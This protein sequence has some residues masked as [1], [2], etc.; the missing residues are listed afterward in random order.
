[1]NNSNCF[2]VLHKD[3]YTSARL[4]KLKTYHGEITTPVFMPV[5]TQASVKTLS[6]QDLK[7]N[8]VEIILGNTYHLYLRPGHN[9]INEMGGLH[10]FI[11][12]NRPILTDSGGFQVFSHSDLR[13]INEDGVEFRSYIDG[14]RHFMTPELSIEIQESLGADI[15]MIFDEPVPYPSTYEYTLQSEKL[16]TKWAKRCKERHNK[17]GQLLFGIVQGGIYEDLRKKSVEEIADIEFD[18]YAIGGLSVGEGKEQMYRLTDYVAPLLPF[19]KPRYLMGVGTPDDIVR[20][21]SMGVDMFDC[22][23][24]TR[25]AR[26]GCLFTGNGKVNIRNAQYIKDENPLDPNCSCYTCKN[27]S[28]AYLRHLFA[29]KEIL[30]LRLNTIHN[31]HYYVTLMK[32]IRDAIAEDRMSELIDISKV[33]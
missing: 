9:I 8:D 30:S 28:L 20:C 13:K 31:I 5:G 24:P 7:D 25:N 26:N 14:S 29:S 32:K 33:G 17:K 21:V 4:G 18:G 23:I 15:I 22:V 27:F 6:P 11:G 2:E 1:M 3:K 19:D 16:T 10:S 12:W